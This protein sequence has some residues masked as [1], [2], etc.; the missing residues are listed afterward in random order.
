MS[1]TSSQKKNKCDSPV[2]CEQHE[3]IIL[4]KITQIERSIENLLK[5][6]Q[7]P[8]KTLHCKLLPQPVKKKQV[9]QC[10]TVHPWFPPTRCK[11]KKRRRKHCAHQ[12]PTLFS[13]SSSYAWTK[14]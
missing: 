12:M 4:S 13:Y 9:Q 1:S 14:P 2:P 3:D 5:N 6:R 11:Y 7:Q 8:T 10:K